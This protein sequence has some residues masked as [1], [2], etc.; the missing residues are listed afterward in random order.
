MPQYFLDVR[1]LDS[2]GSGVRL[3]PLIGGLVV[4]LI[5]GQRLQSPR[6]IPGEP[7]RGPLVS[8]KVVAGTGFAIMAAA[9]AVG[10]G[11]GTHSGT[12]FVSAW[13][14][15]VG[16]GLG[17]SLPTAMNAAL[18]ALTPERSG[19]GSALL[20]AMRQVGGTI[21]VAVLGTVLNTVYQ[22]RLSLTG[23]PPAAAHAAHDSVAGGIA[24]AHATGSPSLLAAVRDAY[25]GGLDVMLAVCAGIA[26]AAALLAALF[27]PRQADPAGAAERAVPVGQASGP[28]WEAG[29]AEAAGAE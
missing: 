6:T 9:L 5:G 11:T 19:S 3:L 21:G 7:A 8:T 12:G 24:V 28:D 29:M 14:A 10:T 1:G 17:L 20:T 15:V 18:G 27:L 22:G 26:L 23:L 2:L 13:F 16:L 25:T 4:G